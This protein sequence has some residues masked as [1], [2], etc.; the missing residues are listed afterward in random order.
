MRPFF[1]LF[2]EI[3]EGII[4]AIY[5]VRTIA[6]KNMQVRLLINFRVKEVIVDNDNYVLT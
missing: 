4:V 5:A 6:L 1:I 2:Y 3:L